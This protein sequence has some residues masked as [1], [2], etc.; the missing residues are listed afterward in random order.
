MSVNANSRQAEIALELAEVARTLAHSTRTVPHP[1]DTYELLGAL[2]DAQAALGQIYA[3]LGAW[4]GAA[5]RGLHF[6]G[7]TELG[8]PD[9]IGIGATEKASISLMA[10]TANAMAAANLVLKAYNS[11]GDLRWFDEVQEE[12][13][14]SILSSA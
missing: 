14:G 10:A 4:H 11:N 9:L 5:Q 2:V 7:E 3:H 13:D 6:H 1:S 8:I 12:E